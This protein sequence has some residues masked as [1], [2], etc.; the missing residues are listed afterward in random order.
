MTLRIFL[1]DDHEVV[2]RGARDMLE[3]VDDFEVVGEAGTVEEALHRPSK[4]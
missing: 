1:V 3:A 4:R 2:R